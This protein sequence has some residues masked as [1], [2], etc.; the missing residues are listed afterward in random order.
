M[1]APIEVKKWVTSYAQKNVAD[2]TISPGIRGA[3]TGLLNEAVDGDENRHYVLFYLF[4]QPSS[5]NL[6]P[7][8]W[9]ALWRWIKPAKDDNSG[10]WS[11]RGGFPD[12][13][14]G[15]VEAVL[16]F[17]GLEVPLD[18]P[19]THPELVPQPQK[20]TVEDINAELGF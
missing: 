16:S 2:N 10:K 12:E 1:I 19:Q 5:K 9:Y 18:A 8:E 13:A 7:A 14:R 6:S 17:G 20:R 4:Q 3:V 15:I 11:G